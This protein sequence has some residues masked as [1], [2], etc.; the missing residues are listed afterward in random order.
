MLEVVGVRFEILEFPWRTG[1]P[2]AR[3]PIY[4]FP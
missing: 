1:D 4:L 3:K 2:F